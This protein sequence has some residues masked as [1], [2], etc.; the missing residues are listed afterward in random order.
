M[1]QACRNSFRVQV[2]NTLA[3]GSISQRQ[4]CC[5]DHES[6]GSWRQTW[7]LRTETTYKRD[8]KGDV[9]KQTKAQHCTDCQQRKCRGYINGKRYTYPGRSGTNLSEVRDSAEEETTFRVQK[10]MNDW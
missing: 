7:S 10:T 3:I 1:R 5:G 4:G 8:D 6:E 2:P 9:A